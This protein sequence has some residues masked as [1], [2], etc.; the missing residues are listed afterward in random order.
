VAKA[1]S[2]RP[3]CGAKLRNKQA[4]CKQPAGYKTPHVGEGRCWL[5]GGLTPIRHGRYSRIKHV[6]VKGLLAE[7]EAQDQNVLD[8]EPEARLM[9]AMTIDFLNRYDAFVEMLEAWYN[10]Q[11][12]DR[13]EQRLPPIPRRI[14]ELKDI[15]DL[16]EGTSRVVERIHKIQKEGSITLDTFRQVLQGLGMIVAKHVEDED[17]L[18]AIEEEWSTVMVDPKSFTR[19]EM[20]IDDGHD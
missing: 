7:L 15:Q 3:K 4:H 17:V 18:K 16:V 2:E 14:P 19:E 1:T 12:K 11:D 20:G 5:H 8:L 9:R 6:R 13:R 10:N